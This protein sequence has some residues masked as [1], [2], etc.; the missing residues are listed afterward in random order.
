[1]ICQLDSTQAMRI[2]VYCFDVNAYLVFIPLVITI[3]FPV[4]AM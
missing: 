3:V 1:M 2:D 4:E